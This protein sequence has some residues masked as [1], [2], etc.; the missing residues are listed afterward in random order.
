MNK[1]I[2]MKQRQQEEINSLPIMFAFSN[3]QFNEGMVEKFGLKPTSTNIKKLCS[4]GM[5]GYMK[6]DEVHLLH[7]MIL[8]HADEFN[9]EVAA[10]K[11]GDG[12]IY[13][14]FNYELDNHEYCITLD[15][16]E[17]LEVL[18]FTMEEINAD[19]RLLHGFK[20]AKRNNMN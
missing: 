2:E 12:F 18:G 5:G 19:P 8:R 16:T 20:K 17:T 15:A 9:K 14:A 10:D 13:D 11:T 7:E 6:K 4:I 1:Y 3:E